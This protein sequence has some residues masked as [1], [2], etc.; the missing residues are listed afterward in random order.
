MLTDEQITQLSK[1]MEIPL[2]GVYFKDEIPKTIEFNKSYIINL[3]DSTDEDG[4]DN[5]GTHW[6]FFQCNKYFKQ[7]WVFL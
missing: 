6:T 2:A 7:F 3:Q 1:R 4:N 5:S